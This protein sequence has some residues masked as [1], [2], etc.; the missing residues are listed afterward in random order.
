MQSFFYDS[1][2]KPVKQNIC[3]ETMFSLLPSSLLP[4]LCHREPFFFSFLQILN[5]SFLSVF[6]RPFFILIKYVLFHAFPF[7]QRHILELI[8]Y[9]RIE[10][11]FLFFFVS[12]FIVWKDQSSFNLSFTDGHL[13]CF[14]P[15]PWQRMPSE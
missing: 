10:I 12:S 5:N 1:L 14:P 6:L 7:S 11:V 3:R 13:C 8:P 15:L 2:I 9:Q 4:S